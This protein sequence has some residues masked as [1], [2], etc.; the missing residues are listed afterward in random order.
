[1]EAYQNFARVYD[2]FMEDVDYDGWSAYLAELLREY[3]VTDGLVLDLACG[4]GNITERLAAAGYDMIG[5]DSSADMLEAAMEKRAVSGYDILYLQ[6]DMRAF[7]LYGTVRAVVCAFD[8]LNYILEEQEVAEV[9]RLVCNYL[10]PGGIFIFDVN[11]C[12][13]YEQ[14]GDTTIAEDRE[15]ASFIW[16]NCYDRKRRLNEY[17][18][19]LFIRGEDGRY[20]K[21]E[22]LHE[23]RAYPLEVL[24]KLLVQNGLEPVAVYDAFTH[25][26]AREE[27]ERVCVVAREGR[28]KDGRKQE[29]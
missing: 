27:S 24:R 5:A 28:K 26:P 9:F 2:L 12:Y 21:Y 14:L 3:G 20:D 22:E 6:Q 25:G 19:T 13:K 17:G 10:D 18:L 29:G 4:T 7:E 23:Q 8:S 1:M 16:E 15:E 11:T